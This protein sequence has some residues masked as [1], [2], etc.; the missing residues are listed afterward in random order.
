[1]TATEP[2]TIPAKTTNDNPTQT[3]TAK[4]KTV[5]NCNGE[6]FWIVWTPNGNHWHV[7]ML[8]N[9][10]QAV[11]TTFEKAEAML[12]TCLVILKIKTHSTEGADCR[13]ARAITTK[14]KTNIA[15]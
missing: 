12:E 9:G 15:G 8:P 6:L 1:M 11:A 14:P 2:E 13:I 10:K 4:S 7:A 3:A 5:T